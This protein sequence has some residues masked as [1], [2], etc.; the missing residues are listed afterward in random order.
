MFVAI[1]GLVLGVQALL[2]R[3]TRA[4]VP[5]P[6]ALG[7]AGELMRAVSTAAGEI[8]AR[9]LPLADADPVATAAAEVVA[10]A[11][12]LACLVVRSHGRVPTA[13]DA[14]AVARRRMESVAGRIGERAPTTVL[15]EDL[16]KVR[17]HLEAREDAVRIQL[18]ER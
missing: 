15:V 9:A 6:E 8:R 13:L 11:Y 1:A 14:L 7:R 3:R 10:A 17:R 4:A 18:G 5:A 2:T 12:R 16:T